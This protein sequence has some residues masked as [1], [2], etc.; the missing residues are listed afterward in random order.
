MDRFFGRIR[1]L[2][3][4]ILLIF[5]ISVPMKEE[6][7][8]GGGG[9]AVLSSCSHNLK[10]TQIYRV[11]INDFV[12]FTILNFCNMRKEYFQKFEIGRLQFM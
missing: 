8:L 6:E 11:Q 9:G 12:W 1:M 4:C 7:R 10:S 5:F 3:G 2:F